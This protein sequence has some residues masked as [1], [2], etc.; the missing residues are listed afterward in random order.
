MVKR[1]LAPRREWKKPPGGNAP[2]GGWGLSR[3]SRE[4]DTDLPVLVVVAAF[5]LTLALLI[6]LVL[7]LVV[8]AHAGGITAKA[9]RLAAC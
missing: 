3:V 2:G 6:T 5:S 7:A 4:R 8:T 9:V 1:F